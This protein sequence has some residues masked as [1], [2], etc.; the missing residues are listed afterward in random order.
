MDLRRWLEATR[1]DDDQDDDQEKELDTE[2]QTEDEADLEADLEA[3]FLAE[4]DEE[5][6]R[7][8]SSGELE[9]S[10]PEL[11]QLQLLSPRRE[12]LSNEDQNE[13]TLDEAEAVEYE[14]LAEDEL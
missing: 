2:L 6:N 10:K 3:V 13:L 14:Y 5:V 12:S 9:D 11:D 8:N 4:P 1:L 7:N